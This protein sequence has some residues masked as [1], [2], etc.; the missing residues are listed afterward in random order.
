VRQ[1]RHATLDQLERF[2]AGSFPPQL[3]AQTDQGPNSRERDFPL[4]RTFW[5]FLS[6]VLT[7]HTACRSVVRQ[8]QAF[9]G[10]H[11]DQQIDSVTSAYVTARGR[12]PIERLEKALHH[13]ATGADQRAGG[14]RGSVAGR[15]VKVVDATSTQLPDTPENLRRYPQPSTQK[16]G[17]GFPVMKVMALFSLASGAVLHVVKE[18]LHWH[19]LRLFRRLWGCL[20]CNDIVVGDR[21]FSDSV[22]LASLPTRAVDVI[23]RLHQRRRPDFRRG[24]QRRGKCDALFTWTKPWLRPHYLTAK[25]WQLVPPQITVRILRGRISQ[26]G[27]RTRQL[28]LVTTLL[29]PKL[30]PAEELFAVYQRRWRREL[31]FRD[32]K[33]TMGME[34]LSR[35]SPKMV[36]KELLMYLIAHNLI[37]C[38]MAEAAGIYDVALDRISFKGAIDATRHFSNALAKARTKKQRRRLEAAL[39]K[40]LAE[41]QVPDRP[42]RREPRAVKRR[43]KPYPLLNKPRDKYQD[44]PHR[45]RYTKKTTTNSRG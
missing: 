31:C 43:P 8:A 14:S 12:L 23:G 21:A 2:F 36:H 29:D 42:G 7:P 6:Q 15:P 17:C 33:T 20:R 11:S 32:L 10:L 30:S 9:L 40:I 24:K 22:S 25:Q 1:L 4:R 41:D 16:P 13:T 18:S 28:I 26:R 37:R 19:D 3:L 27:F 5:L 38:L 45:S 34:T 44:I 35:R 39:L